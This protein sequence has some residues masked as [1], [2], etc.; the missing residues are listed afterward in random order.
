MRFGEFGN[1]KNTSYLYRMEEK[2]FTGNGV[3]YY[4]TKPH[5]TPIDG[6]TMFVREELGEAVDGRYVNCKEITANSKEELEEK[7]W[8]EFYARVKDPWWEL[9]HPI[10]QYSIKLLGI[11][12]E[13]DNAILHKCAAEMTSQ[14]SGIG[15]NY[16]ETLPPDSPPQDNS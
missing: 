7:I 10:D 14:L 16:K 11:A 8:N 5:I 13:E 4:R 12:T 1:C 6:G 3:I 15:V 2:V 9:K